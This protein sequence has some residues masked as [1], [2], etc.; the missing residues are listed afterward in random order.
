MRKSLFGRKGSLT[1]F[2]RDIFAT[3]ITRTSI[4]LGG[5]T[6]RFE[7]TEYKRVAGVSFS[8][9]FHTGAKGKT[10]RAPKGPEELERL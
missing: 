1:L 9:K 8:Y 7:E 4:T 2:V 3:D 5:R 6:S 10:K